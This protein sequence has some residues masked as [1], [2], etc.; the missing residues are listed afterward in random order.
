MDDSDLRFWRN[1]TGEPESEAQRNEAIEVFRR[2]TAAE[3]PDGEWDLCRLMLAK[4]LAQRAGFGL[5]TGWAEPPETGQ[6]WR[7]AN[8]ALGLFS[9]T[10]ESRTL[11]PRRRSQARIAH[12]RLAT[13]VAVL[14]AANAMFTGRIPDLRTIREEGGRIPEDDEYKPAVPLVTGLIGS[15][16]AG[17]DPVADERAALRE[18]TE[19]VEKSTPEAPWR[20]MAR[21]V[22]GIM[23]GMR[24]A[25]DPAGVPVE[26]IKAIADRGLAAEGEEGEEAGVLHALSFLARY[27][28]AMRDGESPGDEE[29][30][31]DLQRASHLLPADHPLSQM[32][33]AFTH[34]LLS[35]RYGLTG[36]LD[37][38]DAADLH[39]LAVQSLD[40]WRTRLAAG[41]GTQ[42]TPFTLPDASQPGVIR[43]LTALDTAGRALARH[44]LSK[45]DRA[46]ADV[47]EHLATL[48]LAN[49]WQPIIAASLGEC[50]TLRETSRPDA[51]ARDD[52]KI[53]EGLRLIIEAAGRTSP[54]V[55]FDGHNLAELGAQAGAELARLTG[56]VQPVNDAIESLKTEVTREGVPAAPRA[57][58]F[59][60]L[61]QAHC[62]RFLLAGDR[63]DL[64]DGIAALSA[65]E[66]T[67]ASQPGSLRTVLTWSLAIAL[68]LRG[69]AVPGE[70]G[71]ADRSLA[72][73]TGL[74]ALEEL[75]AEVLLQTGAGRGLEAAR[76][77][78]AR[79]ATVAAW[80]LADGQPA[81]AV[82]ALELG[83]GLVLHATTV[84]ADVPG[85]LHAAGRDD[86]IPDWE[87]GLAWAGSFPWDGQGAGTVLPRLTRGGLAIP[88][89]VRFRVFTALRDAEPDAEWLARPDVAELGAA[90]TR[91]GWDAF[92]YLVPTGAA[93]VVTATAIDLV[94]LPRL[95]ES[96]P[97]DYNAALRRWNSAS[98]D[99]AAR[100][101]WHAALEDVCDWAWDAVMAPVLALANGWQPD[102]P[103]RLVLIPTGDLGGIPWHAARTRERTEPGGRPHYAIDEAVFSY[104]A[105]ARQFARAAGQAQARW[106]EQPVIVA[107]PTGDLPK[108]VIEATE[109]RRRYYPRAE[110]LGRLPGA[111]GAGTP[112]Q[113]L[114]RLPGGTGVPA[115]MV[116]WGCHA[117]VAGSLAESH[118]VLAGGQ[119]LAIAEIVAQA[120]RRTAGEPGFLAVLGSC[121]SDLADVDRDEALTL[122]SALL[123]AGAAGVV[124]ARWPVEDLPMAQLLVMFHHYLSENPESTATALRAA[125]L[126]MLD[127]GRAGLANLNGELATKLRTRDYRAVHTWAAFTYQGR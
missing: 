64:D 39:L 50:L 8:E 23:T 115:S 51:T 80:C 97:G 30:L 126:W 20:R 83:R 11:E 81:Q 77:A 75:A 89:D 121:L 55:P 18:F 88:P 41:A 96:Q 44:D 19:G 84:A 3:D 67:L 24:A 49:S 116:H 54:G 122:A 4:H 117:T 120:E 106:D 124:G 32:L 119:K 112:A 10:S 21:S 104:A 26:Q 102:R 85:L 35:Q 118:L 16:R 40:E 73:E 13:G 27:S 60:L 109:I 71:A 107:N 14:R 91:A 28:Q 92:V 12:A 113:V 110:L 36:V 105:T 86:L 79:G 58:Q 45:A 65:A 76:V 56:D 33:P 103:P 94:P 34:N 38:R 37:D 123:A 43:A 52:S 57:R 87:A 63:Q 47:R 114:D 111:T 101:D 31:A 61:G 62:D 82:Q 127:A 100:A 42:A 2:L 9:V 93:L 17:Q 74:T 125:Q 25:V 95:A 59:L 99:D 68:R 53:I 5:I 70:A 15:L 66:D 90:L 7:D 69:D 1:W 29:T 78:S 48:D 72:I 108:A 46:I 22:L 6:G 98:L